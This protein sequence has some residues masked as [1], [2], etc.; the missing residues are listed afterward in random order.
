LL[1]LGVPAEA[2][3][4]P[5]RATEQTPGIF[6]MSARLAEVDAV[7]RHTGINDRRARAEQLASQL[8]RLERAGQLRSAP[9]SPEP[10]SKKS[11]R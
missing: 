11:H 1:D 5:L 7:D 3:E 8:G 2:L 10:S 4:P 6:Q 9:R